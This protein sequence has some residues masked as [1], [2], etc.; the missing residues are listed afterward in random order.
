MGGEGE[1]VLVF[2]DFTADWCAPCRVMERDTWP[3]PRLALWLADHHAAVY[4]IEFD[5]D[6]MSAVTTGIPLI[7]AYRDGRELDRL[8][9]LRTADE[10]LTWFDTVH[11]GSTRLESLRAAVSADPQN[12]AA[13]FELVRELLRR[14]ASASPIATEAREQILW[15]WSHRPLP[16]P[17]NPHLPALLHAAAAEPELHATLL[18]LRPP[19]PAP[20]PT[21]P[22]STPLSPQQIDDFLTLST[23]LDDQAAIADLFNSLPSPSITPRSSPIRPIIAAHRPAIWSALVALQR[24]AEAVRLV[25]VFIDPV[26]YS[27]NRLKPP[28]PPPGIG[29]LSEE[30]RR[31]FIAEAQREITDLLTALRGSGRDR[32]AAEV[33]RLLEARD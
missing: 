30:S 24:H 32:E 15:L 5:P 6:T 16:D 4:R 18:S 14:G 31:T 8:P 19:T 3:D 33:A 9:S 7:I 27:R 13:R 12:P 23:A 25:E 21:Q 29:R 17:L 20:A 11:R 26:M 2:A 28:T 1:G 22:T 10:L